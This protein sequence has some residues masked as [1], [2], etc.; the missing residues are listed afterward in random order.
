MQGLDDHT[1]RPT[2]E[3]LSKDIP[4]VASPS[5]AKIAQELGFQ[6]VFSIAH[7]ES[8]TLDNIR[9]RATAGGLVGP[10]WSTRENGFVIEDMTNGL[11]LYYE[12]HVDFDA[13]SVQSA[14]TEV[15]VVVSPCA[16][17]TFGAR[18]TALRA[19]RKHTS[20][21]QSCGC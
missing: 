19:E 5:A 2:L 12:P 16:N 3:R 14:A 10:P 21:C 6:L 1:H 13:K 4:V 9:F 18:S 15:D 20:R 11:R 8:V 7:N 17:V